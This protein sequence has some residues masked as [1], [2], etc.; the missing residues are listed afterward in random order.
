MREPP[1]G[2]VRHGD[3]ESQYSAEKYRDRLCEAKL[4]GSIGRR[5]TPCDHA[6]MERV[7]K[8]LKVACVYPLAFET[9]E[10]VAKQFPIFIE[11]YDAKRPLSS[12][13]SLSPD[14]YETQST[15]PPVNDVA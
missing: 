13:G 8:T 5:G 11:K 12:L 10:D 2:C 4:V 15:R 3:R 1:P 14:Q 6:S 7:M 9:A